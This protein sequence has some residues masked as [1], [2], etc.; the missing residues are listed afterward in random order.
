MENQSAFE[1]FELQLNSTAIEALKESAKWCKF[2]AIIGFV[3]VGLMVIAGLSIGTIMGALSAYGG[4]GMGTLPTTFL[5]VIYIAFAALYFFPV[6]YLYRYATGM[7]NA[8]ATN[9]G[10]LLTESLINLKSHHKFL[11]VMMAVILSIYVL[12]FVFAII[13]GLAGLLG[14]M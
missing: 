5:T 13:G 3:G 8:I 12:F 11:G 2:L 10:S 14:G 1:S 6:L 4:A 9:N 7:K